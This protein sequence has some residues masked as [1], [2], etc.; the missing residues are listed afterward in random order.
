MVLRYRHQI[1]PLNPVTPVRSAVN[2][3]PS[4]SRCEGRA[5]SLGLGV[6]ASGVR[7]LRRELEK[8]E[9]NV[10]VPYLSKMKLSAAFYLVFFAG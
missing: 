8:N 6:V 9:D 3:A 10:P 1:S 7:T 5:V 4:K 2:C